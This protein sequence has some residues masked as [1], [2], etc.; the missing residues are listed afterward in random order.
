MLQDLGENGLADDEIGVPGGTGATIGRMPLWGTL[1]D[2]R[3]TP[4]TPHAAVGSR[5]LAR[6]RSRARLFPRTRRLFVAYI[7]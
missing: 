2:A 1:H 5:V 4:H 7:L 3:A 6:G